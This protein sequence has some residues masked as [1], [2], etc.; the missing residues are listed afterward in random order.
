LTT[1]KPW[2][3]QEIYLHFDL[4]QEEINLI[5]ATIK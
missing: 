3:D 5:E 1:D 4:T 2:T